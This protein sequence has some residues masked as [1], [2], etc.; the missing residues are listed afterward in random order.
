MSSPMRPDLTRSRGSLVLLILFLGTFTMGSAELLVVGVLNLIAQDTHASI[1]TAGSLVTAYALGQAIGG[2]VLTAVTVRASRR[3]VLLSAMA[4]YVAITAVIALSSDF[5]V[6]LIARVLTGALQGLVVAVAITIGIGVVSPERIGRAMSVVI[7]GFAVSTAFG[8]PLGTLVGQLVGWRGGFFGIVFVGV[9]VLAAMLLFVPKVA[10]S[11]AMGFSSQVRHALH[12]RVIAVLGFAVLLFAGQFAVLTYLEPYLGEVTGIAGGMVSVFLLVF[13]IANALGTFLG[14]KLADWNAT[15]TMVVCGL[16]LAAALGVLALVGSLP[17]PA[18][19]VLGVWGL[20][21]FAAVPSV[22]YRVTALAGPGGDLA[23]SLPASALNAG[24]AIGALVGGLA[25]TGGGLSAITVTGLIIC[26]VTVPVG[27][28]TG[29]LK[30]PP[31]AAH[32]EARSSE[33]VAPAAD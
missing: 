33:A 25:L 27:W 14:G 24:I 7:G 23:A 12:P 4:A 21:G 31:A 9:L 10:S 22:Q 16:V 30:P 19:V 1:S 29:F 11:G 20:A 3:L 13:G 17:V 6:L 28:A 5:T 15:L 8:V 2:P 32:A 26:A 18:A